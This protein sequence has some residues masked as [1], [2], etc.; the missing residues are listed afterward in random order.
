MASWPVTLPNYVLESG[1]QEQLPKN[2]VETD[3]EGGPPKV[4]R[5]FTKTF[6]RFNVAQVMDYTQVATFEAF[7][8]TTCASGSLPFDWVHPR[9]QSSMS[10]RFTG[11]PPSYQPFGGQYVRV[12]YS[13]IEV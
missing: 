3:M 11:N 5:R 10:F 1:Y 2:V 13:L 7:Y 9:T 4:R 12:S 6:R 8:N